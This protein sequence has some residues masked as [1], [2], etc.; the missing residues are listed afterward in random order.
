MRCVLSGTH[1]LLPMPRTRSIGTFAIFPLWVTILAASAFSQTQLEVVVASDRQMNGVAVGPDGRVFAGMPRWIQENSFSVGVVRDG[2][3]QPYP[4]GSWNVWKPGLAPAEHFISVNAIRIEADDPNT[5]WV[6]DSAPDVK[7]GPKLVQIDTKINKVSRVYSFDVQI[8]PAQ[9]YLN[10]V[11]IAKGHAFMSE[12]GTG[13]VIVVDLKSG[14]ARRLLANSKKTKATPGRAPTIDGVRLHSPDGS[15]PVVN[16]DGI[17][18]SP[19]HN[20]FYYC[21]PFGGWLWEVKTDDLL[22]E[23]LS[24]T[25]LESRVTNLGPLIP[26]G[27]ILML[28]SGDLLLSDTENHAIQRRSLSGKMTLVARSPLLDWPDAMAMGFDGKVYA[29]TPQ[30]NRMARNN[31]GVE[32]THPPFRILRFTA[33]Q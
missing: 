13:A 18:I 6:V 31:G 14:H 10:D 3:I 4:G 12:S 1:S 28:P 26:V 17:E 24:E 23:S 5:L 33:P 2:R 15:I 7:G 25:A 27:G 16:I 32:A 9:S 21:V 20:I 29:A 22:N 30:A 8:T 11:R 19:D